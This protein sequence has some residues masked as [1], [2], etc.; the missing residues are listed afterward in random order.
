MKRTHLY[1]FDYLRIFAAFSVVFMHSAAGPYNGGFTGGWEALNVFI[2]LAYTAVPLFFMMSGFLLLSSEKTGSFSV[3]V[4]ERLPRLVLPLASWSLVYVL[5]G[6]YQQGGLTLRAIASGMFHGLNAPAWVH[7][8]FLYTLIIFYLLSPLLYRLLGRL[9][10]LGHGLLFGLLVGVN[11]VIMVLPLL[12]REYTYLLD[13]SVSTQYHIFF[14]HLCSF[15]LG[16][17]LG[18]MEKRIPNFLLSLLGLGL[19]IA[20]ILGTRVYSF[21]TGVLSSVFFQQHAG[22]E[23]ALAACIFLLCKQNLNRKPATRLLLPSSQLMFGVY[24]IHCLI[25][26]ILFTLGLNPTGLADALGLA[27]AV[28]FISYFAVKTLASLRGLSYLFTGISFPAA[29]KSCNWFAAF[30]KKS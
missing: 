27:V 13:W 28:Y 8:W 29:C 20:I 22:Y 23:V 21:R 4:E 9:N 1:Y 19:W 11:L 16:Y 7:L 3:L 24:L 15:L 10:S 5:W 2:S 30:R 12:P 26:S 25:L 18:R 14:G 6:L 17:Y